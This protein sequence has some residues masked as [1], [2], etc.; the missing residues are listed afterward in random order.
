VFLNYCF[1]FL[2]HGSLWTYRIATY[3]ILLLGLGF[4]A[5]VVVLR[6]LV[7]PYIDDYRGT[8]AQAISHAVGQR[9]TIGSIT[10][11]WDGYRP[12]MSLTDVK[13]FGAGGEPA[14]ALDRV[15]TALSWLSLLSAEWR[16][17][18]LAVYGP[19]LDVKRRQRIR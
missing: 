17:D 19:A 2:K 4:V 10:G 11:S 8:I 12:E 9:V 16:F 18:S 1:A 15:T 6:Y 14:L 3:A 13:V 7:L 5:T